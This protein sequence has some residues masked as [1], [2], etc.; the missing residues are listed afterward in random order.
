MLRQGEVAA[1]RKSIVNS[2]FPSVVLQQK[3]SDIW[4]MC[5]GGTGITLFR[6]NQG[7][8]VFRS[9]FVCPFKESRSRGYGHKSVTLKSFD[10]T[11]IARNVHGVRLPLEDLHPERACPPSRS[12]Y[13]NAQQLMSRG[14]THPEW[15]LR[16]SA[17]R[18]IRSFF[19]RGVCRGLLRNSLTAAMRNRAVSALL[20]LLTAPTFLVEGV[21]AQEE[22]DG[23]AHDEC[24]TACRNGKI[25]L[26]FAILFAALMGGV[27]P[28]PLKR[29]LERRRTQIDE[30][31]TEK[32]E[33][34]KGLNILTSSLFELMEVFSGGILLGV[35]MLHLIPESLE[36]LIH[37]QEE[38]WQDFPFAL[39]MVMVGFLITVG[40]EQAVVPAIWSRS[41]LVPSDHND[42]IGSLKVDLDEGTPMSS[43]VVDAD[44]QGDVGASR[45]LDGINWTNFGIAIATF[46][47]LGCHAFFAG[48]SLGLGDWR[49]AVLL[50]IAIISHKT[51]AAFALGLQLMRANLSVRL[52]VLIVTAFAL[53]TPVGIAIGIGVHGAVN[54]IASGTLQSIAAGM[55]LAVAAT[56][57]LS[58]SASS[59]GKVTGFLA[60]LGGAA[61]MTAVF[62]ALAFSGVHGG[63]H[64]HE[65]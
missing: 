13:A 25:G 62:A 37:A 24:S 14:A 6:L 22:P 54:E 39:T 4:I 50:F 21:N 45:P 11:A 48:L 65:E 23:E 31:D 18:T 33:H 10:A 34:G 1:F 44:P 63:A 40:L 55:L 46:V 30:E 15:I 53:V 29:F 59:S 27:A 56:G 17:I 9:P 7:W 52:H 57:S 19:A 12:M 28:L 51:P 3:Q 43:D 32:Q 61:L 38:M 8:P 26:L 42:S 47:G 49:N 58:V 5:S 64:G 2:L 35:A 36:L 60:Y 16:E 41:S 20:F